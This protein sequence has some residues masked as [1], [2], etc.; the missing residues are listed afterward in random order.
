MTQPLKYKMLPDGGI[1]TCDGTWHHAQYPDGSG[2]IEFCKNKCS[3]DSEQ[4]WH[5]TFAAAN[6]AR[7]EETYG[8]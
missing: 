6:A 8:R 1:A 5:P 4:S 2:E 7:I 3:D